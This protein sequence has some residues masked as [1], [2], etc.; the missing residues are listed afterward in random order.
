MLRVIAFLILFGLC[1]P[2]AADIV[3]FRDEERDISFSYND[4]LWKRLDGAQPEKLISLEWRLLGGELIGLC[5]LKALRSVYAASIE[6]HDERE[7]IT[8]RMMASLRK[9]DPDAPQLESSPVILGSQQLI[10]LRVHPTYD[11]YDIPD[12][13]TV[14]ALY[15]AY[16]GD[17][18]LF[19]CGYPD[20]INRPNTTEP[21]IETEIRALMK[22]LRFGE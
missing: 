22:T 13:H 8:D 2:A 9:R 19:E 14:V 7:R 17:E 10:E 20:I 16:H 3:T 5:Y 6:V 15:T 11:R 21:Y 18:I 4:R 12:R 1:R